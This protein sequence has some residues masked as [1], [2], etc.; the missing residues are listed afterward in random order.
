MRSTR[1]K[2][3]IKVNTMTQEK[4]KAATPRSP[5]KKPYK[6][7]FKQH[8]VIQRMYEINANSDLKLMDKMQQQPE[9]RPNGKRLFLDKTNLSD[10]QN[11]S[12]FTEGSDFF[13][14]RVTADYCEKKTADYI[15]PPV[16][17]VFE[18]KNTFVHNQIA[19]KN[20][21][22]V[23]HFANIFN[24]K[25]FTKSKKNLVQ[26]M[27]DCSLDFRNLTAFK[28]ALFDSEELEDNHLVPISEWNALKDYHLNRTMDPVEPAILQ[29]IQ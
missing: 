12:P 5:Y 27:H 2:A 25:V 28:N 24:K 19:N 3:L 26:Q 10:K 18:E 1:G 22:N 11:L 7:N 13:H 20:K 4:E 23:D 17:K 29:D 21:V 14:R 8:D 16:S 15:A 9:G 6:V